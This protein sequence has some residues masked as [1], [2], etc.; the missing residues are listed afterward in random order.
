MLDIGASNLYFWIQLMYF[1]DF[2][3]HLSLGL[4]VGQKTAFSS[5]FAFISVKS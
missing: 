3:K 5:S 2:Y 4:R 1:V